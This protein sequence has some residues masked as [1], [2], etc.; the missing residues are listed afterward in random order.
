MMSENV[1]LNAT[2]NATIDE[3]TVVNVQ[4]PAWLDA[5]L[6]PLVVLVI[7]FDLLLMA[8]LIADTVTVR[9]IRWILGNI[10]TA[11]VVGA[12]GSAVWH[13]FQICTLF[14]ANISR[15]T[16]TACRVYFPLMALGNSGRV[17]MYTFYTITVFVVV[18]CWHKPVLAPNNTKYFI[19]TAVAVWVLVILLSV[20]SFALTMDTSSLLCNAA[21]SNIRKMMVVLMLLSNFPIFIT[22]LFLVITVCLIK[23]QAIMEN[24]A[25]KKALLN[26]GFF[27]IIG[28]GINAAAQVICPA[29][30]LVLSSN[31]YRSLFF[32][33]LT[34]VFDLSLIPTPILICIFF[35]PVQL[36]LR[37]LL[38]SCC[39][40][41]SLGITT[42]RGLTHGHAE[43]AKGKHKPL[44]EDK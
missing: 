41:C 16:L 11:N 14:D 38:C 29:V 23:R 6:L 43:L 35:K 2:V 19:F 5:I 28:Q 10:L 42:L 9:S 27:L 44:T 34:A 22:V 8:A 15:Y 13:T 25:A 7:V 26:L 40:T 24:I 4:T 3:G 18:T 32:M 37:T 20:P 21:S 17:L 39:R 36:K 33:L 1:T 30:L 31:T 12:F